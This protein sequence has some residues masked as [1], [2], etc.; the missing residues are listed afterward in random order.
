MIRRKQKTK[1][2]L[3]KFK[4]RLAIGPCRSCT[5][6]I[7]NMLA[8]GDGDVTVFLR[9]IIGG[10]WLN[11][12]ADYRFFYG[13]H[14]QQRKRNTATTFIAVES[15]CEPSRYDIFPPDDYDEL[16]CKTKPLFLFRQP[17]ETWISW[18]NNDIATMIGQPDGKGMSN[19]EDFKSAY[20]YI[21]ELY[22]Q[23]KTIT[24]DVLCLTKN[25]LS[26]NSKCILQILCSKW[27]IVFDECM[28]STHWKYK[29]DNNPNMVISGAE[30]ELCFDIN[31]TYLKQI[32]EKQGFQLC[33]STDT[34]HFQET[35]EESDYIERVLMPMYN[36]V[37][38]QSGRD[39]PLE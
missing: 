2:V 35:P 11:G 12:C 30:Q 23:A 3:P 1:E 14:S 20:E 38:A 21:Y 13:E 22:K 19:F 34:C 16:I 24:N 15:V 36:E 29:I 4:L 7:A 9:P 8:Q 37:D 18:K 5:T 27:D 26:K 28:V 32:R 17:L 25:H 31:A 33:Q 10:I 39:F 6:A